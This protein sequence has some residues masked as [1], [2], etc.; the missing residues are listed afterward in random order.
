MCISLVE[1]TLHKFILHNV[2]W[3]DLCE[4][5]LFWSEVKWSEVSYAEV[6]GDK[7]TMYIRVTLYLGYL[8]VLWLFHFVC[9]LYCGCFNLFCKM[10]CVYLWVFDNCVGALVICVLVFTVPCIVCS[11]F[12]YCFSYVYLFL[13]VTSVRTAATE[14]QLNCS[15]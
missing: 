12:L 1:V 6:L 10:W 2:N 9:I 8:F 13:F 4:V 14:W 7:S 5:I 11:V 15:K 3:C